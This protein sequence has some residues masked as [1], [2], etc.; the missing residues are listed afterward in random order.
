MSYFAL[1]ILVSSLSKCC[2][3]FIKFRFLNIYGKVPSGGPSV[4]QDAE[5][6]EFPV[7]IETHFCLFPAKINQAEAEL[8]V[9]RLLRFI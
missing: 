3:N 6:A 2:Y 1:A 9:T 8:T 7:G 5:A 4:Q